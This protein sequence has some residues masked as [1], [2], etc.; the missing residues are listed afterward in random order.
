M[1]AYVNAQKAS[2]PEF[3]LCSLVLQLAR[4]CEYL[5]TRSPPVIHRDIKPEN[6]LMFEG[7]TRTLLMDLDV[8][9]RG[10]FNR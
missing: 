7:M 2:V 5:H 9:T 8:A 10:V 6:V 3:T 1:L 4:A